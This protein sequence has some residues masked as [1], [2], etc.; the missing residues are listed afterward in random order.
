MGSRPTR[1][2]W[3]AVLDGQTVVKARCVAKQIADSLQALL[4]N[5]PRARIVDNDGE[6]VGIS[7]AFGEAGLA[8]F[9]A[10][11]SHAQPGQGYDQ[12]AL[13][14]L[15]R[16]ID[17]LAASR[18]TP[19][20]YEGFTGVAWA[21]AHLH[22][23]F[24]DPSGEDSNAVIDQV[25]LDYVSQSPWCENY[26]LTTGL[27]GL[28]VYALERLPSP[29]AVRC[30]ECVVDRLEETAERQGQ[31]ITWFTRPRWLSAELRKKWRYPQRVCK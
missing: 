12:T 20:L 18:T 9:Y 28:G 3:R 11:M 17:G 15:G 19:F 27:V 13:G 21:T 31:G 26:D 10:Y 25:L 22:G 30:L 24:L 29:L 7:L 5:D 8:V 4:A 6:D 14:L 16:S 2:P 23:W 1:V